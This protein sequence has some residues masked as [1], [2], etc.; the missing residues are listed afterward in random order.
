[1]NSNPTHLRLRYRKSRTKRTH[2]A[3]LLDQVSR[4]RRDGQAEVVAVLL[5][6]LLPE[7]L[8]R[9]G[10]RDPRIGRADVI[11][12]AGLAAGRRRIAGHIRDVGAQ[13]RTGLGRLAVDGVGGLD[14]H[15]LLARIAATGATARAILPTACSPAAQRSESA[16]H[17]PQARGAGEF[18]GAQDKALVA[19]PAAEL[20]PQLILDL[21]QSFGLLHGLNLGKYT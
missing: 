4:L 16:Q 2:R 3:L 19:S 6:L 17:V 1:M 5:P 14:D 7:S 11:E 10:T 13:H 20:N 8:S 15:T 18:A 12:A 9:V 21:R